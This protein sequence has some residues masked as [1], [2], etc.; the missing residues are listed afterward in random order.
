MATTVS[1]N[2]VFIN[3]KIDNNNFS[4]K[5]SYFFLNLQEKKQKTFPV[6]AGNVS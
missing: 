3:K 4:R 1:K 5:D 2:L 6:G